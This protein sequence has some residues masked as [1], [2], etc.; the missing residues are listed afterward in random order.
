MGIKSSSVKY[1]TGSYDSSAHGGKGKGQKILGG[2]AGE[3]RDGSTPRAHNQPVHDG[4][5]ASGGARSPKAGYQHDAHTDKHH[6]KS[7]EAVGHKSDS[8]IPYDAHLHSETGSDKIDY[9]TQNLGA[10]PGFLEHYQHG[11][12]AKAAHHPPAT[13][14]SH[15]F[16][17]LPSTEAHGYGHTP[18]QRNGWLRSSGHSK[19][20]QVGRR[21]PSR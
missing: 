19:G 12:S 11:T 18:S 15:E 21:S 6:G 20:H 14:K 5:G 2:S 3:G 4:H 7:G 8:H 1:G 13:G 10:N 9:K 17:R 16:T